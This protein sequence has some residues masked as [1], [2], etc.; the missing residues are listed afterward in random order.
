MGSCT[1]FSAALPDVLRTEQVFLTMGLRDG[2][3]KAR[4]NAPMKHLGLFF[5]GPLNKVIILA[6]MKAKAS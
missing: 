6:H 1:R 4:A 5:R 3:W 2:T